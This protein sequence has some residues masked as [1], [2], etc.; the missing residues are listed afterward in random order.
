MA[1]FLPFFRTHSAIG[2]PAREPWTFGE[3]L[4]GILREFLKL[5]QRILPYYY[6][7]AWVA[8]QS[9]IPPLRPLWWADPQDQALWSVDDAFL[10][11]DSLLIAPILDEG[12]SQRTLQ[13]PSGR[14]YSFWD[15]TVLEGPGEVHLEASLERI[16]VLVRAGSLL[17]MQAGASWPCISIPPPPALGAACC[18]ATPATAMATSAWT[19][20]ACGKAVRRSP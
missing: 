13:L 3:P 19:S 16:P 12:A 18:I 10:L 6:T 5:R 9:G 4:L 15:E 20:S 2:I 8:S 7:L 14:W 1:A 17:P 11:G